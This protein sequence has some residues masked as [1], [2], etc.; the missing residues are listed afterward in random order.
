M[1][2][3]RIQLALMDVRKV[4]EHSVPAFVVNALASIQPAGK[5]KVVWPL[6][7]HRKK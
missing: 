1:L 6:S 3:G 7:L 2:K 5:G 4:G